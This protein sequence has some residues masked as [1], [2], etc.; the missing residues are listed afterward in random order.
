MGV[1]CEAAVMSRGKQAVQPWQMTGE[2]G[3]CHAVYLCIPAFWICHAQL[4]MYQ[5][6]LAM[7]CCWAFLSPLWLGDL[8][9]IM[10]MRKTLAMWLLDGPFIRL[11]VKSIQCLI[12]LQITL[13]LDSQVVWPE[14][15]GC[16]HHS[17][18]LFFPGKLFPVLVS[19][20]IWQFFMSLS[21]VN[22]LI[23][24]SS[25]RALK[26]LLSMVILFCF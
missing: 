13:A 18:N 4:Q 21:V 16:L 2:L 15:Q 26:Y 11:A 22:R 10:L 12:P 14:W 3:P 24:I 5:F 20:Q 17:L 25:S 9:W 7:D 23:S 1:S 6:H 8:D 19:T